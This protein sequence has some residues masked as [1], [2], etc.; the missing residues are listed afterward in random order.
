[1][2]KALE[3][4]C[5]AAVHQCLFCP[6]TFGSASEKDDHILSHFSRK[7]CGK[8]NQSLI[9]IGGTFYVQHNA[10]TCIKR[11]CEVHIESMFVDQPIQ[12]ALKYEHEEESELFSDAISGPEA[13]GSQ[14]K[15]STIEIISTNTSANIYQTEQDQMLLS[16]SISLA[17]MIIKDEPAD[18]ARGL[19]EQ[20][21][22]LSNNQYLQ[23]DEHQP[24]PNT[25]QQTKK[26]RMKKP[27]EC[28]I[29]GIILRSDLH[30]HKVLAHSQPGMHFCPICVQTFQTTGELSEHRAI[31]SHCSSKKNR[32]LHKC[33]ICNAI[34]KTRTS[35]LKHMKSI[36]SLNTLHKCNICEASFT[37]K[38]ALDKHHDRHEDRTHYQCDICNKIYARNDVLRRHKLRMHSDPGT[39][40]C[41]ICVNVFTSE[42]ELIEHQT[43]CRT[44]RDQCVKAK[45]SRGENASYE[46][47]LCHKLSPNHGGLLAHIRMKHSTFGVKCDVCGLCFLS[48]SLLEKHQLRH[49][50]SLRNRLFVCSICGKSL[51]TDSGLKSHMSLHSNTENLYKCLLKGCE[52]YFMTILDR[53][54]HTQTHTSENIEA[55]NEQEDTDLSE[56]E[57][58]DLMDGRN[59]DKAPDQEQLNRYSITSETIPKSVTHIKVESTI[60]YSLDKLQEQH[61]SLSKSNTVE[62]VPQMGLG[63]TFK[64]EDNFV[65]PKDSCAEQ[66]FPNVSHVKPSKA[67]PEIHLQSAPSM[68]QQTKKRRTRKQVECDVCG[69]TLTSGLSRHKVLVHSPPGTLFCTICARIFQT[70]DEFTEHRSHCLS[71]KNGGLHKCNICNCTLKSRSSFYSHMKFKHNPNNIHKCSMCEASFMHKSALDKHY[72]RHKNGND[73]QCNI[74]DKIYARG[75]ILRRHKLRMHS[76]P[77]TNICKIC[78]TVFATKNQLVEHQVMCRTKRN[79]CVKATKSRNKNAVYECYLCQKVSPNHGGLRAHIRWAH[80]ADA[81]KYKCNIC[82]RKYNNRTALKLHSKYHLQPANDRKR[83]CNVCGKYLANNEM[84]KNHMYIHTNEK[85]YKC[86]QEGCDKY[87]RTTMNRHEHMR[88][89]TG[90]KPFKCTVDGCDQRFAYGI[91]FKRH[92]F[93]CHG[94]F[95]KKIP[96]TICNEIFPENLL[97]KKHMQRHHVNT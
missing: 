21:D 83:M 10:V 55:T 63:D 82:D 2:N 85:P 91:D 16:E 5:S 80:S 72:D 74:C 79:Q 33:S 54:N 40:V 24:A 13:Q 71:R 44:K 53:N 14:I 76:D 59:L 87:F 38:S 68:A 19:F 37:Q 35:F 70:T 78:T 23:T 96:C 20:D 17:E 52:K 4:I 15:D 12:P 1:M 42:N 39:H 28:D 18:G 58:N 7:S 31:V 90:E 22:E 77:G 57:Q 9:Q 11:D 93:K 89:H 29:C 69:K 88:T 75:D 94:I 64:A 46:C 67:I 81:I 27:L 41:N 47:Y 65:E 8:C 34:L 48:N 66:P 6:Q 62:T 51:K 45:K 56:N 50:D 84:L 61:L 73:Y 36:H 30:R 60:D 49:I 95:T 3:K 43:M 25:V 32:G 86:K 97:L 26:R 92:K